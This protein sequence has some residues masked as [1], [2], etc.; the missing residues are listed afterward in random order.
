MVS[1][2]NFINRKFVAD[3]FALLFAYMSLISIFWMVFAGALDLVDWINIGLLVPHL[4]FLSLAFFVVPDD[5]VCCSEVGWI[6]ERAFLLPGVVFL[7]TRPFF[8]FP[9]I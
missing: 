7:L 8:L 9:G 1:H 5:A 4:A 2:F 3:E 6:V